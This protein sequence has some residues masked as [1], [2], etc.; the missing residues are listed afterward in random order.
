MFAKVSCR[1]R[2]D[3]KALI[4]ITDVIDSLSQFQNQGTKIGAV[5]HP[6]LPRS[7][8]VPQQVLAMQEATP[9]APSVPALE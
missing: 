6:C 7:L 1:I 2:C 3:I 5:P 4:Y 8:G 9:S